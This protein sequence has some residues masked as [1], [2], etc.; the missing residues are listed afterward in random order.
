MDLEE[1]V[2]YTRLAMGLCG[3]GVSNATAEIFC[4]V[5]DAVQEM[6]GY[7]DLKTAAEIQ[8]GVEQKY[9]NKFVSG[10]TVGDLE[11]FYDDTVD[12]LHT[13]NEEDPLTPNMILNALKNLI[14]TNK[15][16]PI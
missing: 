8:V 1:R 3:I 13:R 10:I 2:Q 6:K 14:E 7:F 11:K 5:N 16:I 15:E 12:Q 4:L 9:A